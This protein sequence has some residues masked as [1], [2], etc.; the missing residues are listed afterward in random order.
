MS[1]KEI[2]PLFPMIV[3]E[4]TGFITIKEDTPIDAIKFNLKNILLT[5]PGENLS[6]PEFGVGLKKALFEL[7]TSA[8][9]TTLRQRIIKQ[10]KRYANYFTKLEVYVNLSQEFSNTLTVRLEF[11]YGLKMWNDSLEVSVSI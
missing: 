8:D 9:I 4:N 11:Q 10:I 7:E 3:K 1:L 2:T 6:D 5:N